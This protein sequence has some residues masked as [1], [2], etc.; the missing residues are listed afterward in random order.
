VA[1]NLRGADIVYIAV[2]DDR[3]GYQL[4]TRKDI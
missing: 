3:R 4:A 2:T 1:A